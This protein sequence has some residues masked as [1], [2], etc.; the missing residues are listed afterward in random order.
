MASLVKK[1]TKTGFFLDFSC[2]LDCAVYTGEKKKKSIETRLQAQRACMHT[3][4]EIM[5]FQPKC[6]KSSCNVWSRS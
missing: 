3:V 1:K 6:T 5:L 2:C 4:P